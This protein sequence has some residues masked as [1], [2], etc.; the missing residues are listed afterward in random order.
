MEAKPP[1]RRYENK[2]VLSYDKAISLE[3]ELGFLP[4]YVFQPYPPRKVHSLYFDTFDFD[5]YYENLEGVPSRK[6]FRLRWYN[7]DISKCRFEIKYK[8]GSVTLKRFWNIHIDLSAVLEGRQ[9]LCRAVRNTELPIEVKFEIDKLIPSAY[10][11]YNRKYFSN[12]DGLFRMTIDGPVSYGKL[13]PKFLNETQSR[14]TLIDDSEYVFEIKYP[15]DAPEH[16][17][18]LFKYFPVRL[19]KNSK[20]V[21]AISSFGFI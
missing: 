14:S 9:S 3:Q 21:K 15:V 10:I 1:E 6:K 20:Y 7:D 4:F 2:V 12:R 17:Q 11:K 13:N 8:E 5:H 18:E 16:V 19:Y